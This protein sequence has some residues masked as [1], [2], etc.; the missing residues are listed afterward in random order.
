MSATRDVE[1]SISIMVTFPSSLLNIFVKGYVWY[2]RK[3]FEVPGKRF[4]KENVY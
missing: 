2:I 1:K 3:P 4:S